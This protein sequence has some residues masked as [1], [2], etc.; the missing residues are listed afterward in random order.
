MIT[1]EHDE[2]KAYEGEMDEILACTP[3]GTSGQLYAWITVFFF[4]PSYRSLYG[5]QSG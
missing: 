1:Q 5:A 2:L 3:E 4:A